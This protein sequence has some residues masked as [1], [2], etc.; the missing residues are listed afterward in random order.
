[1][2][3]IK[4]VLGLQDPVNPLEKNGE[5][6]HEADPTVLEWLNGIFPSCCQL[7]QYLIRLFPFLKWIRYYNLQWLL[8]DLIAGQ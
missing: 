1:M 5:S 6:C 2:V 3:L 7:L 8:G 4:K